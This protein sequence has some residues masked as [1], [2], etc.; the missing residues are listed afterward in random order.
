[1]TIVSRIFELFGAFESL[2][3]NDVMRKN[4]SF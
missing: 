4:Y 3:A 1:M 2:I